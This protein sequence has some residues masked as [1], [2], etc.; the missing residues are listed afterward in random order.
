MS[1]KASK[2]IAEGLIECFGIEIQV[3]NKCQVEGNTHQLLILV[4]SW[5]LVSM[6]ISKRVSSPSEITAMAGRSFAHPI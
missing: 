5:I 2:V 4:H 1:V 3:K 6:Q